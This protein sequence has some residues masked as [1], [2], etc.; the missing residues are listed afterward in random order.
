MADVTGSEVIL[1]AQEASD[2]ENTQARGR[3][4]RRL[5]EKVKDLAEDLGIMLALDY[6]LSLSISA[7]SNLLAYFMTERVVCHAGSDRCWHTGAGQRT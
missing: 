3:F 6:L 7:L 4:L 5:A 2:D 1:A